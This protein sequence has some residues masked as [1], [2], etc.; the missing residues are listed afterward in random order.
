MTF[1]KRA[2]EGVLV[3]VFIVFKTEFVLTKEHI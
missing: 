2:R 3:T 1:G